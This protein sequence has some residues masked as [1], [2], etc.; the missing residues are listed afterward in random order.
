MFEALVKW[1]CWGARGELLSLSK[2]VDAV[3]DVLKDGFVGN[4]V[5]AGGCGRGERGEV[6]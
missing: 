2:C 4:G 5:N 6:N 1:V 3:D